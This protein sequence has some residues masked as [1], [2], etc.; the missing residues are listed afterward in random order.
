MAHAL[1]LLTNVLGQLAQICMMRERCDKICEKQLSHDTA[2][3]PCQNRLLCEGTQL[4]GAECDRSTSGKRP[5]LLMI[6]I[7]MGRTLTNHVQ[8]PPLN[9]LRGLARLSRK[10][11]KRNSG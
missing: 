1:T 10:N 6:Y 8:H 11:P 5:P 3:I 9:H 4:T 2:S 7:N